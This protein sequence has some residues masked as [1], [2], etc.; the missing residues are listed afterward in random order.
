MY[1]SI[2]VKISNMK[3]VFLGFLGK[4]LNMPVE[5]ITKLL[6]K[7]G[8][9]GNATDE[10]VDD[11]NDVLISLD[12]KRVQNLKGDPKKFRDEGYQ[13]AQREVSEKYEKLIKETFGVKDEVTGEELVKAAFTAVKTTE[14]LPEEKVKRSPLYLQLEKQYNEDL[15]KWQREKEE[16]VNGVKSEIERAQKVQK[17][18]QVARETLMSLNPVLPPSQAAQERQINTFL[19]NLDKFGF[20]FDDKGNIIALIEGEARKE[21]AHGNAYDLTRFVKEEAESFFSLQAQTP[22]EGGGNRNEPPQPGNGYKGDVP[23]TVDEFT[24][25]YYKLPTE[26]RSAFAK[27]FEE[28]AKG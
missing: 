23:K 12:T 6:Y 9:D 5:E 8:E 24:A 10:T 1:G 21:D 16:A 18:K 15:Q 27:A 2:F 20:E 28:S 14:L 26:Q 4:T 19:S 7:I 13:R 11:I 17:V 22:R 3:D 25:Q